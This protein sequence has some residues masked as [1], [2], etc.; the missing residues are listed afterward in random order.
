MFGVGNAWTLLRSHT[1]L[2][3]LHTLMQNIPLV[4]FYPGEYNGQEL[5]LFGRLGDNNYYR[6]FRLVPFSFV[7]SN[8]Q[9]S[10]LAPI[11]MKSSNKKAGR[12]SGAARQEKNISACSV[13]KALPMLW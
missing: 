9:R 6:A 11:F 12:S 10:R 1:L 4:V 7:R 3:N 2:N 13:K 5:S 8:G